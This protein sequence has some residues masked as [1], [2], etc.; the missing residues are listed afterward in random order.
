M[1]KGTHCVNR[2]DQLCYEC[3]IPEIDN[4]TVF[5]IYCGNFN[6]EEDPSTTFEDEIS[7]LTVV[8]APQDPERERNTALRELVADVA[9]NVNVGL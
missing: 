2:K 9:L 5:H 8:D 7:V 4:G 1:R 6:I 3:S